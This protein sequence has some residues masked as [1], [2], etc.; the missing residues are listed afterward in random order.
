MVRY[1]G[2]IYHRKPFNE[3]DKNSDL[4]EIERP[5]KLKEIRKELKEKAAGCRILLRNAGPGVLPEYLEKARKDLDKYERQLANLPA[6]K[7]HKVK[8]TYKKM[9]QDKIRA[10]VL[11]QIEI[12]KKNGETYITADDVAHQLGVKTHFVKQVFQQ[13]N[14]EGVLSQPIH[15]APHDSKRDPWGYGN[16]SGWSDDLYGILYDDDEE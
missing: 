11:E 7:T 10:Y 6:E 13:L 12:A 16:W 1:D 8:R 9:S 4:N 15:Y 5:K 14:V 3:Q 2:K